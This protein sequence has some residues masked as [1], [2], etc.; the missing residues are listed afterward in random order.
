MNIGH[1]SSNAEFIFALNGQSSR[2]ME[3][4]LK[5]KLDSKEI[6]KKCEILC[7]KI[8]SLKSGKQ[9]N[10]DGEEDESN[11]DR[12]I[13]CADAKAIKKFKRCKS[14]NTMK[15]PRRKMARSNA[16]VPTRPLTSDALKAGLQS[17]S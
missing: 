2:E 16:R 1:T 5:E 17:K 12:F 8:R 6:S 14:K 7:K 4:K 9:P 3:R 13:F 15:V 10:P 11:Y